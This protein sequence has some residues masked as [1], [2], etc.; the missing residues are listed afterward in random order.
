VTV[1]CLGR[2]GALC[3]TP[4]VPLN[5][6][7]ADGPP[8]V[9]FAIAPD[10]VSLWASTALSPF[11]TDEQEA[12]L[13]CGPFYSTNCD[14]QGVDLMNAEAT[15]IMQ[16]WPGMEGTFFDWNTT[17]RRVAQPGT[18]GFRGGPVCTRVHDGE[19]VILPGCRG[20]GD[21]G[22]DRRVDGSNTGQRHPFTGQRFRSE[23]ATLSWNALVGFVAN[24]TPVDPANPTIEEFDSRHPFRRGA[25]SFAQPYWCTTVRGIFSVTGV[26]RDSLRAAGNGR[27]GRRDFTWSGGSDLVL[28][29]EK[30]NVLGTSVDFAEDLT[31]TNWGFEFTWIEGT[32]FANNDEF[33]GLSDADT[34][35]L[36]VSVDRPT[37]VNFLNANRTFFFNSQWFFQYVDGFRKGFTSTGP[38]NVLMTFTVQSGYFQD[39]L[40]PSITFVYDL[41]SNSGAVLPELTYLFSANFSATFGVALFNGRFEEKTTPIVPVILPERVGEGA[42]KSHV[43]NALAVVRERDEVFLRLRYTF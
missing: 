42:Y 35:N 7:P 40:L 12:L 2:F 34:Y 37:F 36:T 8:A 39:R 6:D 38:W 32:P 31:K 24:A 16:S 22:Y 26:Q 11:L 13:G 29:Y 25:C 15:A 18:V 43:E 20:P 41:Q 27:F 19:V 10:G 21:R 9:P 3:P 33:D 28:R 1:F 30:R 23:M 5:A 14:L 4:L 17:D